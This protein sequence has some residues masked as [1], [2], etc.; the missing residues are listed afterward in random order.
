MT[1]QDVKFD[2]VEF[3]EIYPEFSNSTDAQLNYQFS[4]AKILFGNKC[5]INDNE[6]WKNLLYLVV[7]HL[8][9]LQNKANPTGASGSNGTSS[10]PAPSGLVTSATEGSVS[11]GFDNGSGNSTSAIWWKQSPY[12]STFWMLTA[13]YRTARWLSISPQFIVH[14]SRFRNRWIFGNGSIS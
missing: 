6:Q 3:R 2:P 4:F 5:L 8:S 14:K 1:A 12:G 7:A 10:S 9:F 13:Q 11:V